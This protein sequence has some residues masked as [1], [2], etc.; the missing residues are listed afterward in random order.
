MGGLPP[1][2]SVNERRFIVSFHLCGSAA[3]LDV[4]GQWSRPC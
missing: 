3:V 1:A 2:S 4:G